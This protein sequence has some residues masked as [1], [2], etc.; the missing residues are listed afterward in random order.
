MKPTSGPSKK[1]RILDQLKRG[2]VVQAMFDEPTI[3]GMIFIRQIARRIKDLRDEGY[4]IDT[5]ILPT[6][7]ARYTLLSVPN[8]PVV[9]ESKVAETPPVLADDP[10]AT[11]TLFELPGPGPRSPYEEAA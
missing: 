3:D 6:G 1:Q 2:P 7:N 11:G 8:L 10:P 4:E 5:E 9:Q